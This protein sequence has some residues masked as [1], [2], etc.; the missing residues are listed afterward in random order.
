[1]RIAVTSQGSTLDSQVDP[2]F[3]RAAWFVVAD[4][5]S[6]EF[7]AVGNPNASAGGGAGVQAAQAV[8]DRNATAVLTGNCGPKAFVVLEE[9]GIQVFTGASGTVREALGSYRSGALSATVKPPARG[10]FGPN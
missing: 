9:A 2:R 3:G 8:A 5:E 6:M 10:H 1:M 4:P 7:E